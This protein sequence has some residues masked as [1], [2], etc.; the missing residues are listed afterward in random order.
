MSTKAL[1]RIFA[2]FEV[3]ARNDDARTFEGIAAAYTEDL[4]GDVIHPGAFKRT[5]AEWKSA[6]R[7]LPLMDHHPMT[8]NPTFSVTQHTLGKLLDAEEREDGLWA[9]F[10]VSKT[11]AG[12]DLLALLRDGMVEGLSIGYKAV[13]PERDD[14]GRR[15][16][17]EIRLDEI[18]VVTYGMNPDALVNLSS[19]KSVLAGLDREH[20]SDEDR[21]E[22]RRLASRIG[23][24][25]KTSAPGEEPAGDDPQDDEKPDATPASKAA[26]EPGAAADDPESK[27]LLE[28][29]TKL[30]GRTES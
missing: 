11:R 20:L 18:S 24:L 9:K 14:M 16:L 23:N 17:R 28:R 25:L 26:D 27:A 29:I 5:L 30:I 21:T 6:G 1:P 19:V 22:L 13:N 10:Q 8:L 3:K 7:V 15:H 12:D 4:G 2:P